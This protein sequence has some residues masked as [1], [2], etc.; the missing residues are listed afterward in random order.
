MFTDSEHK[1][2]SDSEKI[3]D[4]ATDAVQNLSAMGIINGR[5][6]G[7]FAPGESMTR[8]EAAKMLMFAMNNQEGGQK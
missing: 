4:Y 1:T 2:Y 6:N 7:E 8:A 5:A 3:A